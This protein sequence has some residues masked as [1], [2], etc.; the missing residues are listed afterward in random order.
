[1]EGLKFKD[2]V[3]IVDLTRVRKY[4]EGN[5]VSMTSGGF[6]V[7]G[8]LDQTTQGSIYFSPDVGYCRVIEDTVFLHLSTELTNALLKSDGYFKGA[9]RYLRRRSEDNKAEQRS[10]KAIDSETMLKMDLNKTQRTSDHQ[11]RLTSF[12]LDIE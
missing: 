9:L 5:S 6:I 2:I 7:F 1:M 10:S 11:K 8:K 4:A 3:K 12:E